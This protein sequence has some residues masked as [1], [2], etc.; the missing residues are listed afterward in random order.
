MS[1]PAFAEHMV[2]LHGLVAGHEVL[3]DP[4]EHMAD[5]G[6][7][8]GRGR[9]VEE[10]IL[11]AAIAGLDALFEHVVLLPEVQHLQL[12]GTSSYPWIPSD[13]SFFL[14]VRLSKNATPHPHRTK[15][16]LSR[17]HLCWHL[18]A[19]LVSARAESG[20]CFPVTGKTGAN[21]LS[22]SCWAAHSGDAGVLGGSRAHTP[23]R[24]AG[25]HAFGLTGPVIV[26]QI[27]YA[28]FTKKVNLPLAKRVFF[29]KMPPASPRSRP[30]SGPAAQ[31]FVHSPEKNGFSAGNLTFP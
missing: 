26:F 1:Q 20:R 10:H 29:V 9:A 15:G 13:T 11:R 30:R 24:L 7:A 8:V 2:A 22:R 25:R 14:L 12:P 16:G 4:G 27:F 19:Q 17:Y 6:L 21:L 31:N 5:V 28:I 3:H 18:H 23:P